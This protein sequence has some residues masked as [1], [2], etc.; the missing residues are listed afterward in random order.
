M[1]V[2]IAVYMIPLV[3]LAMLGSAFAQDEAVR[4]DQS[5]QEWERPIPC[6]GFAQADSPDFDMPIPPPG[7]MPP[8][9]PR[10]GDGQRFERLRMAKLA[11]FLELKEDQKE[12]VLEAFRTMRVRQRQI[13][14]TRRTIIDELSQMLKSDHVDEKALIAKTDE[15]TALERD[16]F[17]ELDEFIK[18]TRA[19]LT[20]VQV[21][22]MAIFQERFEAAALRMVREGKRHPGG[23]G[24]PGRPGGPDR[25][26]PPDSFEDRP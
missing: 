24:G 5:A 25:P 1:R 18:T 7:M 17:A 4:N 14:K 15:L 22:K 9:G 13:E 10:G 19:I 20:P 12:A 3:L 23:H 26:M 8:G 21:A 16:R 6:D 2:P 11:E